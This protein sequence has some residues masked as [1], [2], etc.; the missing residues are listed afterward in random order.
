[1]STDW[2]W[3]FKQARG[4]LHCTSLCVFSPELAWDGE[5][6]GGR[7]GQRTS[8]HAAARRARGEPRALDRQKPVQ[9]ALPATGG[10]LPPAP[11][12]GFIL[13]RNDG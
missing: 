5:S 12:R 4:Y 13:G 3:E 9:S 8:Q 1:M 10:A 11:C 2:I 7:G 6:L